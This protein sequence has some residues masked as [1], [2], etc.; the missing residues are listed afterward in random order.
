MRVTN[1]QG[2]HA[3]HCRDYCYTLCT[4]REGDKLHHRGGIVGYQDYLFYL[5][6]L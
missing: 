1:R 6:G 2:I 5:P 3:V 4:Q